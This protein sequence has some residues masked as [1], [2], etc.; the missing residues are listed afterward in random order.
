MKGV[1]NKYDSDIK[2]LNQ[3]YQKS[4]ENI[5]KSKDDFIVNIYENQIKL[6][7]TIY[8]T[9]KLHKANYFNVKN[10]YNLM[11]NYYNNE[12]IY[13]NIVLKIINFINYFII[14]L[15]NSNK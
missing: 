9:F 12:E 7:E 11:I 3:N 1:Q 15:I 2:E 8:N 6:G 13:N 5:E 14:Y 10:M 4:L